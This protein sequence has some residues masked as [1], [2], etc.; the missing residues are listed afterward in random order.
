MIKRVKRERRLNE[1]ELK[2]GELLILKR[3]NNIS[4]IV[5]PAE[6]HTGPKSKLSI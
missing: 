2:N 4:K 3:E 6:K 5:R 1:R